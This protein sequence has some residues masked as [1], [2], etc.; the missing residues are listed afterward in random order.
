VAEEVGKGSRIRWLPAGSA[1]ALELFAGRDPAW[2]PA[3]DRL[4]YARSVDGV[5][6]VFIAHVADW[7]SGAVTAEAVY[8]GQPAW[9]PDGKRLAY[10][11][12]REGNLDIWIADIPGAAP[13]RLTDDAA[14]D[15]AP[16]W[17]PDGSRLA[18][19]SDRTGHYQVYLSLAEGGAAAQQVT[20]FPLGAESPA[21]S[22]EGYWLAV[23]A[24]TGD[25]PGINAREIYLVRAD[26]REMVRLTAN[27]YDD[28]HP[29]WGRP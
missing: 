21:W 29:I 9:S 27:R 20:D 2:S 15:W 3:G 19:V 8:A 5:S 4:A 22:P 17:S 26:G 23:V 10:V 18:F 16:A 25:G 13:L 6:Q 12:E 24:Y 7:K 28:T 1:E 14:T 11:A